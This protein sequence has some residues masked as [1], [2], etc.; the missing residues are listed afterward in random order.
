MYRF[1]AFLKY[2][3][4][5]MQGHSRT[6]SWLVTSLSELETDY[7]KQQIL[8]TVVTPFSLYL[9][10]VRRVWPVQLRYTLY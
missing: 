8:V 6:A 2:D 7:Y 4:T 5:V 1:E 10:A 3:L 9:A